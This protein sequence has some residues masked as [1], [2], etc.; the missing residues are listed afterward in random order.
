VGNFTQPKEINSTCRKITYMG[1]MDR[2]FTV[3][4]CPGIPVVEI[5]SK[6]PCKLHK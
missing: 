2:S 1:T 4:P 3:I 5:T 6:N